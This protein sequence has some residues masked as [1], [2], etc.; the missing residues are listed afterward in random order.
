[1]GVVHETPLRLFGNLLD[2]PLFFTSLRVLSSGRPHLP[3]PPT[4]TVDGS[5]SIAAA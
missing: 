4:G 2:S 1:V 5:G 3:A